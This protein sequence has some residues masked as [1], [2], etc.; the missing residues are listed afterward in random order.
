MTMLLGT[1]PSGVDV[2]GTLRGWVRALPQPADLAAATGALGEWLGHVGLP[3][4]E[5]SAAPVHDTAALARAYAVVGAVQ[6]GASGLVSGV[7]GARWAPVAGAVALAGAVG[8]DGVLTTATC[9]RAVSHVG[10]RYGFAARSDEERTVV[11]AV[12]ATSLGAAPGVDDDRRRLAALVVVRLS[13]SRGPSEL[14]RLLP[15]VG[16]VLDAALGAVV[17]AR[18]LY[19]VVGDA[20]RHYRARYLAERDPEQEPAAA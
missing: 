3:A 15:A 20:D 13:V 2:L 4:P 7:V 16:P 17:G 9:V 8:L 18:L 12:V 19:R 6:A 1:P 11:L 14:M 5:V 10:A